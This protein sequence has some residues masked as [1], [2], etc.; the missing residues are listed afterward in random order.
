MHKR[1]L[2]T[3]VSPM[4]IFAAVTP[5]KGST[6][7][8]W[9]E[10]RSTHFIVLTNSGE[11]R[12]RHLAGQFERM[13]TVFG[14][15]LPTQND[16]AD[17][18]IVVLAVK[19]KKDIRA[20]EP[21][22]YLG[23]NQM[24]LAGFFLRAPEKNY[25]LLRL[26]AA[27]GHAFATVYHEYTHYMLRKA[28]HWLPLWM[29]EGLA[30]YYEN[31]EIDD[32]SAW[33]GQANGERLRFLNRNDL[34]PIAT[35]VTIDAK[36]PYYHDEEKGSIFYAESWALTHYLIV[37]DRIQGTHRMHEYSRLLEQGEN[38]A[39]AAK[40]AFGD[41]GKLQAGLTDY[42]KQRKFM[43]FMMPAE[44]AAKDTLVG[45]RTVS[46]GKADAIRADILMYT[47]RRPEARALA[48]TVLRDDPGNALAHETMGYMRYADG[49]I[50]GARKWYAEAAALDPESY[51][52]HF[53]YASMAMRGGGEGEDDSIEAS[54]RKAIR[55]NPEFAPAYDALA[56]FY[57]LRHR[58]LEEAHLLNLHAVELEP[59]QLSFRL[60][61]AEVLTQERQFADALG[62]LQ[63]AMRMARTGEDIAAVESRVARVERSQTGMVVE[64]TRTPGDE[65][66]GQ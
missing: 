16:N 50:E 53:Y 63:E 24:D 40:Q 44:V 45:V 31:T 26:D 66:E 5:A 19:D 61:C 20:L 14:K 32:K 7:D 34:L 15:L 13:H 21:A 33:L 47:E 6:G 22:A 4:L 35:L 23:K 18:P 57:A 10:A 56:M 39:T 29:N 8:Q 25:I 30:Q 59:R 51:V 41:L 2:A 1:L 9:V 36:S 43:Y 62:V 55:L 58:K 17:P 49:D 46:T 64:R 54:L 42:L 11:E 60:N 48:E 3:F 65:S 28:N 27:P 37:S 12:A 38:S 52:A